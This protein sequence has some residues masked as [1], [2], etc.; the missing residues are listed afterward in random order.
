MPFGLTNAPST[1]MRAMNTVFS[2]YLD[3]FLVSF[4][5]DLLIFSKTIEEHVGHLKKVLERLRKYKYFAKLKKC[6][7]FQK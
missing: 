7:F 3:D 6:E 5:D 1:F 4:L 2:D